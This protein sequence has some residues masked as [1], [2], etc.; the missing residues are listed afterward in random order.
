MALYQPIYYVLATNVLIRM[1]RHRHF[2]KFFYISINHRIYYPSLVIIIFKSQSPSI[3]IFVAPG[4]TRRPSILYL[5]P[6]TVR[7]LSGPISFVANLLGGV[8]SLYNFNGIAAFKCNGTQRG[9]MYK[10]HT[11]IRRK[12]HS[13]ETLPSPSPSHCSNMEPSPNWAN[14]SGNCFLWSELFH[15]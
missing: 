4:S 3:Q 2:H 9:A 10:V 12:W 6:T 8:F 1:N 13:N 15:L 14:G 7:H 5:P 11:N